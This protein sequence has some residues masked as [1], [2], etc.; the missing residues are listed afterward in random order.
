MAATQNN[1]L[2][3]IV[4]SPLLG[5]LLSGLGR[6][7]LSNKLS[8]MISSAMVLISFLLSTFLL[9]T[10]PDEGSV[11]YKLFTWIGFSDFNI[12]FGLFA[13]HLSMIMLM[14]VT[15]IGFLIHLYS[16]GYMKGDEG[17]N[18]F[19]AYL[20]LFVFFMLILVTGSNYL[21]MFIGWE[22][23]GLSSYLLIGFWFKDHVNNNAAK[24]AF[25]I[26]RIGDL[27]FLFAMFLMFFQFKSLDFS[28]VFPQAAQ[29][30]SGNNTLFW[31][32]LL[33]LIGATGKSAQIP[34]YTWLPD[35]MAGPTPVSALIHAATMVTAGVYLICRSSILFVLSPDV[36]NIVAIVGLS[37][38]LLAG[39][40]AVFQYDIKKVLAYSTV[41]QL[42]YMFAALGAGAFSG[43]M[44]HLVTHAFFKALLFLTA[45]VVIHA[46]H[47][48]QDIR[49]MG[50]LG[51]KLKFAKWMFLIGTLAI[52]G[53]PPFS[54]FFSKDEIL[55]SLYAQSPVFWA[56]GVAGAF[57]TAFY[58]FRLYFVVFERSYRGKPEIVNHLHHSSL[59]MNLPLIVLALLSVA[60][61]LLNLPEIM[62]AGSFMHDY[63]SPVFSGSFSHLIQH[64]YVFTTELILMVISVGIVLISS[65]FAWMR[66][67]KREVD[68]E[69][70]TPVIFRLFEARF[71]VDEIYNALIVKPVLTMS[72]L[73]Y[74]IVEVRLINGTVNGIGTMVV[75]LG[76]V[77]RK[78][79][80]GYIEFYIFLMIIGIIA[81]LFAHLI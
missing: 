53:I 37:T 69:A 36:M 52:S 16:I 80:N 60:G 29:M 5:F 62:N 42:G 67:A 43:A 17:F 72:D 49:K 45:G 71:W 54:G 25:V 73:L 70:K 14:I 76:G 31:I 1:M 63:L 28:V 59:N 35:A 56:M 26:N 61:G 6:N 50:G 15:G 51:S 58:M 24:K 12:S 2:L 18:R 30:T 23:V 7:I 33:L 66:F 74:R 64:E 77:L 75:R 3:F 38:A 81:L 78:L 22:G 55:A 79:Q 65:A 8:G 46:L 27:G 34:L 9:F 47:G 32:S 10:F 11:G 41:S 68:F 21:V 48:E 57:L 20:N 39:L 19:F 13:D 44:F 4:L 40:I